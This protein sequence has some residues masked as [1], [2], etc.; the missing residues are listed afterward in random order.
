MGD[1][2]APCKC[3]EME[4][5]GSMVGC[6]L[7]VADTLGTVDR[8]LQDEYWTRTR[9]TNRLVLLVKDPATIFAYWEVNDLR[10]R[11]IREHFQAD[12]LELPF[13]LQLYDVT[14]IRF[15]G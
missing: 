5:E 3:K 2:K 8:S 4:V 9:Q 7:E 14:D 6:E 12:W 11:L 13:F 10:K 1:L 15:D